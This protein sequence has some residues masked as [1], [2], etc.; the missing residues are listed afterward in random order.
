MSK[1][2]L[3]EKLNNSRIFYPKITS[4]EDTIDVLVC[5][6][7]SIARFGDGEFAIALGRSISFQKKSRSLRRRLLE[8][9]KDDKNN[10]CLIGIIDCNHKYLTDYEVRYWFENIK[11]ILK[12]L[13]LSRT[14]SNASITRQSNMQQFL[15]LKKVWDN[16][17]VVFV[18]GRNSRFDCNHELF[19]NTRS[20]QSFYSLSKNAWSNYGELLKSICILT[21]KIENPIVICSLGP[22]AT[23]LSYDLSLIGIRA[24]DLGHFTNIFD[25]IKYDKEVPEKID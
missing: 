6:Q 7:K 11:D 5:S 12:I 16:R 13:N 25:A 20:S 22:T 18:T 17:N 2:Q 10:N 15:K 9:L 19:N 4:V 1:N 14:Y 24:L 23:V 8:I 3:V 21:K